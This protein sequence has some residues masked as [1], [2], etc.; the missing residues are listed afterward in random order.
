MN[1]DKKRILTAEIIWLQKI[2][3]VLILQRIRNGDIRQ[4]FG[5]QITLLEKSLNKDSDG[6]DMSR[7]F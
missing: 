3:G 1:E 2:T 5:S 6:V 4:S 7:E